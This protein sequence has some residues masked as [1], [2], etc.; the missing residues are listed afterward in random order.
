MAVFGFHMVLTMVAA[1]VFS[2][3]STRFSFADFFIF[4]GFAIRFLLIKKYTY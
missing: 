4:K 1:A 2:K 3:M